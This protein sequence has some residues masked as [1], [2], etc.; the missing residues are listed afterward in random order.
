MW[1]NL[2]IL[3]NLFGCRKNKSRFLNLENMKTKGSSEIAFFYSLVMRKIEAW[4]HIIVGDVNVKYR[5]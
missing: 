1:S 4:K 3:L 2:R 5:F